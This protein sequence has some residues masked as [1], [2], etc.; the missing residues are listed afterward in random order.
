MDIR[1][2]KT[3]FFLNAPKYSFKEGT[4][5]VAIIEMTVLKAS[6]VH[7][8]CIPKEMKIRVKFSDCASCKN[9]TK[10]GAMGFCVTICHI[11]FYLTMFKIG[12]AAE[13]G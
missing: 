2:K 7:Y 8:C 1:Q 5:D 6:T 4:R 12:N 9:K 3:Q 13:L 10:M 11:Q